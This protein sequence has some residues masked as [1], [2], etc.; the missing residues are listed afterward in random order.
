MKVH[1]R[2][3]A[4]QAKGAMSVRLGSSCVPKRDLPVK[5]DRSVYLMGSVATAKRHTERGLF[6]TT[7]GYHFQCLLLVAE[8]VKLLISQRI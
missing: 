8:I 6:L 3:L 4:Q 1:I 7:V 5:A 2:L